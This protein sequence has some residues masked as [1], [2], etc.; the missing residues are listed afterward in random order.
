MTWTAKYRKEWMEQN[1]DYQKQWYLERAE[2][3]KQRSRER[4]QK[5]KE[6]H[7]EVQ[8]KWNARN[9]EKLKQYQ[10]E[11]HQKRRLYCIEQLG[12]KCACCGES[13]PAFL[14]IDHVN[15]DGHVHRKSVKSH[16]MIFGFLI[17]N[18]FP[19]G[20]QV[21]CHNCNMAKAFLG[22]CPHAV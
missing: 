13:N 18:N 3:L 11:W 19:P 14:A 8:K 21:L 2:L 5:N 12:G 15:N 22:K 7:R 9:A 17:R 20:F 1:P 16:Y 4:Y 10:R 6:R